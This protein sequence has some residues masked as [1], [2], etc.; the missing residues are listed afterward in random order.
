MEEDCRSDDRA[1]CLLA[2]E[3]AFVL[4]INSTPP[5]TPAHLEAADE[6]P[7]PPPAPLLGPRRLLR[8][9]PPFG[10]GDLALDGVRDLEFLDDDADMVRDEDGASSPAFIAAVCCCSCSRRSCCICRW[11]GDPDLAFR[12]R[13]WSSLLL[14]VFRRPPALLVLLLLRSP[15]RRLLSFDANLA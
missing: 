12:R 8:D 1:R 5:L 15:L 10:F 4:L 9:S 6:G 11:V 3:A 7:P 2:D 14:E 13:R